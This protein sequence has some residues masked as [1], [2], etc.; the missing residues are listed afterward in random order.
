MPLRLKFDDLPKNTRERIVEL[1]HAKQDPRVLVA[2]REW[3]GGWF[4]YVTLVAGIGVCF[5]TLQFLFERAG[6]G[7]RPHSDIEVFWMFFGGVFLLCMS[8]ASIVLVRMFPPPPYVTGMFALPSYL[9]RLSRGRVELVA[10]TEL[11]KPTVVTVLRNGS[12][13]GSRLQLGGGWTFYFS[14]KQAVDEACGKIL[15]AREA[16]SK[17]MAAKDARSLA[18]IDPFSEC[19]QS[20]TWTASGTV[21]AA[22]GPKSPVV[23][24]AVVA[25]QWLGSMAAGATIAAALYAVLNARA[26]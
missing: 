6:S 16:F 17:I 15:A 5:A 3:S 1:S 8:V 22:E 11:G 18:A 25:A 2:Q 19:T 12:Y 10:L 9:M 14:T 24:G 26:G 23:P 13:S 20:G 21:D 7:I 4:K